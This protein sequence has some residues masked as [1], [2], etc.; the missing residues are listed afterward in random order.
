MIVGTINIVLI[1][2]IIVIIIIVYAAVRHTMDELDN[3]GQ[4]CRVYSSS[5]STP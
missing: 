2:T 1:I 3:V 5:T 4:C